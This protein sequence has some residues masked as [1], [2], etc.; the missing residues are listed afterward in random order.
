MLKIATG[1]L[2]LLLSWF[3]GPVNGEISANLEKCLKFFYENTTPQGISGKGYEGICQ[4]YENKYRFATIYDRTRR[5]PLYSAYILSSPDGPRP[6]TPWKIEPQVSVMLSVLLF[7]RIH[8]ESEAA[9]TDQ[10]NPDQNVKDSQ[11]VDEDYTNSGYTRGH[12]APSGHQNTKEDRIATFTLTNIVPQMEKS[13]SGPWNVLENQMLTRFMEI[14]KETM[15][16]ITGAIPYESGE[17]VISKRVH[18]PEYMWTAYCCPT[19]QKSDFFPTYAE[20]SLEDLEKV[21]N[22]SVF[23]VTEKLSSFNVKEKKC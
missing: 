13:N 20:M 10:E 16:V 18:V 21:L 4:I 19:Q 9:H 17:H 2:L 1:A 3:G 23:H 14:C 8:T 7:P 6:K 5:I 22:T 15:Y 12:L 11:A